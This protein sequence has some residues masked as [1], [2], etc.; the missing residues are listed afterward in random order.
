MCPELAICTHCTCI[1]PRYAPA[2]LLC[3]QWTE[4][5]CVQ[6]GEVSHTVDGFIRTFCTIYMSVCS[7]HGTT[8][9]RTQTH[10][11]VR[12]KGL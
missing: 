8:T 10:A 7:M 6:F 4:C 12:R 5:R 11:T 9:K 2:L 3:V 1:T